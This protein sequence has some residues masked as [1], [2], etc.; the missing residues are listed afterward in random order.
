MQQN[1]VVQLS[2]ANNGQNVIMVGTSASR[3]FYELLLCCEVFNVLS[4]PSLVLV[5]FRCCQAVTTHPAQVA[6]SGYK[7]LS[8]WTIN[9]CT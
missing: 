9:R 1:N 5:V 3:P 8:Y 7:I 2:Q 6:F 4:V